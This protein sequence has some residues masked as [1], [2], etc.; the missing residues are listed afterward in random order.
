MFSCHL[1]VKV[2]HKFAATEARVKKVDLSCSLFTTQFALMSLFL[3]VATKKN[4]QCKKRAPFQAPFF[5]Y[6]Y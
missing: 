4:W 1:M 6:C 2:V 3:L 5:F